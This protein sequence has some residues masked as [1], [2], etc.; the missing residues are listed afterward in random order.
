VIPSLFGSFDPAPV[1]LRTDPLSE[2]VVSG[3]MPVEE[4]RNFIDMVHE[5][6]TKRVD[7]ERK[8][9]SKSKRE[10]LIPLTVTKT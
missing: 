4:V 1:Y 6:N 10:P 2:Q 5:Y 8:M 3:V 9:S 7:T